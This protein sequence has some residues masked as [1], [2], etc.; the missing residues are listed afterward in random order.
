MQ[1][2][3]GL[4][5]V[6]LKTKQIE[7]LLDTSFGCP[8]K[9]R[10]VRN[11]IQGQDAAVDEGL[12]MSLLQGVRELAHKSGHYLEFTYESGAQVHCWG[13]DCGRR[14]VTCVWSGRRIDV[15]GGWEV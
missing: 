5:A 11:F 8:E 12:V 10:N 13:V 14:S 6:D 1:A 3:Q 9:A 15:G 7:Q 4:S 2:E